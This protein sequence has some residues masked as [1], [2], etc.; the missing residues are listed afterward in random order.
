MFLQ[1]KS[2]QSTLAEPES[3]GWTLSHAKVTSQITGV[4]EVSKEIIPAHTS[5]RLAIT[6]TCYWRK[7]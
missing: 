3:L 6:H 5:A 1:E 7:S 4:Q 2:E